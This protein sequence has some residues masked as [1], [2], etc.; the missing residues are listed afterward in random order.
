MSD[1]KAEMP[2]GLFESVRE[3]AAA[4]EPE[5]DELLVLLKKYQDGKFD[6]NPDLRDQ[7]LAKLVERVVAQTKQLAEVSHRT[8][9]SMRVG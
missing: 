6:K 1:S 5:S 2:K 9:G 7:I 4:P 8:M 3:Q